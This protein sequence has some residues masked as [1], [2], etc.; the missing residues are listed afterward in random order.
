V[1]PELFNFQFAPRSVVGQSPQPHSLL[2]PVRDVA[3]KL[4]CNFAASP[5]RLQDAR[6]RDELVCYSRI[7]S[8]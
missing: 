2:K 1:R 4:G 5:L 3:V 6:Q 8:V 7:S